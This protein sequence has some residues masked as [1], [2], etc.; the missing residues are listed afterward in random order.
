MNTRLQELL[1][2]VCSLWN[3]RVFRTSGSGNSASTTFAR[4]QTHFLEGTNEIKFH[5]GS[6]SVTTTGISGSIGLS[7][8]PGGFGE[9][10]SITPGTV[11]RVSNTV[12]NNAIVTVPD[13][14]V[15]YTLK[16]N[17]GCVNPWAIRPAAYSQDGF[18]IRWNSGAGATGYQYVVTSSTTPPTTG[19][20]T[21]DTFAVI[22]GLTPATLHYVY[23]RTACAG[24]TFSPWA[25]PLGL[26][27][28]QTVTAIASG[29]WSNTATWS[30]GAVP[31][32]NSNVIISGGRNVVVDANANI[33]SLTVGDGTTNDTLSFNA[34]AA[35]TFAVAFN[36]TVAPNGLLNTTPTTGTSARNI[37]VAGNY[38]NNGTSNLSSNTTLLA[39]NGIGGQSISGTGTFANGNTIREIQADNGLTISTPINV[40][41]RFSLVNGVLTTNGNLTMDNTLGG[42]ATGGVTFRRSVVTPAING[43]INIGATA[44]YNLDYVFFTGQAARNCTTSTEIPTSRTING[45]RYSAATGSFLFVAG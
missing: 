4:F 5:Y 30:T 22:T 15:V 11:I 17:S 20:A 40:S 6:S 25:G 43:A 18:T 34:S 16:P 9:F 38:I 36:I 41:A 28:G 26:L 7:T 27:P 31:S 35:R 29:N 45:L 14:G 24:G 3:G 23:V 19:T 2:T 8:L 1:L 37:F 12:E 44:V 10:V 33:A 42:V 39:F 13:S 32:I 21:T